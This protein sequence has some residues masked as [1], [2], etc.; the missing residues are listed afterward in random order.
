MMNDGRNKVAAIAV[1]H[2]P[3]VSGLFWLPHLHA[4]ALSSNI[5]LLAAITQNNIDNNAKI[6]EIFL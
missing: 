6:I 5:K 2:N 1:D 3:D 4:W